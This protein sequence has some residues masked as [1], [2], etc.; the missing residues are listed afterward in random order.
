MEL[1]PTDILNLIL[2]DITF[3]NDTLSLNWILTCKRFNSFYYKIFEKV[4]VNFLIVKIYY[5]DYNNFVYHDFVTYK[6]WYPK[7]VTQMMKINCRNN[8]TEYLKECNIIM[9]DLF[10]QFFGHLD[11]WLDFGE[12]FRFNYTIEQK[13]LL[14][15]WIVKRFKILSFKID[16]YFTYRLGEWLD[17]INDQNWFVQ[18]LKSIYRMNSFRVM[19]FSTGLHI[20]IGGRKVHSILWSIG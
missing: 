8:L 6:I 11:K 5:S 17:D 13:K 15:L 10:V 7:N 14:F 19:K 12:I 2:S 16:N 1:L 3:Q 18:S 20:D 4:V 9:L